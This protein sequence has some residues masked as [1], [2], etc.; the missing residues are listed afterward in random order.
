VPVRDYLKMQG[1]F[2]HLSE[3]EIEKIQKD[4]DRNWQ[5]LLA[6]EKF[7]QEIGGWI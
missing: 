1:R 4:V 3:E 5:I 7:T 2:R 6:K